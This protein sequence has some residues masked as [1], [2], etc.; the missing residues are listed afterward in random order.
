MP[1]KLSG[2]EKQSIAIARALL[3]NP[4]IIFADEPTGNLDPA[5]TENIMNIL[6]KIRESGKSV[7]MVTHNYNVIDKYQGKV[8]LCE[9]KKL[10]EIKK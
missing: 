5:S 9:D 8:F 10:E 6:H 4:S 1:N 2:G 7:V 3:N